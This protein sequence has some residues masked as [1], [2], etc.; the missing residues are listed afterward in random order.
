LRNRFERIL[1]IGL[2]VGDHFDISL[3]SPSKNVAKSIPQ[4]TVS[5]SKSA[6]IDAVRRAHIEDVLFL[7]G[8]PSCR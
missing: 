8:S 5:R 3:V 6:S 4:L 2:A 1:S 7:L